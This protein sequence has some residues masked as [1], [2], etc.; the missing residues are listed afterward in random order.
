MSVMVDL[1]F[2]R[3]RIVVGSISNNG[4]DV[5]LLKRILFKNVTVLKFID[6]NFRNV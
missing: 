5:L 6:G 3:I 1:S 4:G 2:P